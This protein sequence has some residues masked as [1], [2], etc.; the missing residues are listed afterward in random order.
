MLQ[1]QI[2]ALQNL[3]KRKQQSLHLGPIRKHIFQPSLPYSF[4]LAIEM[5]NKFQVTIKIVNSGV[6]S[7]SDDIF[8]A[9]TMAYATQDAAS[10]AGLLAIVRVDGGI[11]IRI[12]GPMGVAA[13]A[14]AWS[15]V[16]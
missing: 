9:A 8:A 13:N 10:I 3:V 16:E 1:N 4:Y 15:S 12:L 5:N 6:S 2:L 14:S 11:C 7:D